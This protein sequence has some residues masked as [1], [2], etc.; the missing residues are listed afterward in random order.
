MIA[1]ITDGAT[2]GRSGAANPAWNGTRW[3][4]ALKSERKEVGIVMPRIVDI[5]ALFLQPFLQLSQQWSITPWSRAV[6]CLL[7]ERMIGQ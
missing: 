1:E 3:Y 5:T 6:A 2:V 7:K 4:L